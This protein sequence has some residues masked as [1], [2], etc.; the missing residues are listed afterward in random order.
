[1]LGIIDQLLLGDMGTNGDGS[2]PTMSWEKKTR[3]LAGVGTKL[4]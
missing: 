2:T 4:T 3:F 1:M